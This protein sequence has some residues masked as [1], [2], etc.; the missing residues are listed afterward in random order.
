MNAHADYGTAP[1]TS[2]SSGH[3]GNSFYLTAGLLIADIVGV[4][5]LSMGAVMKQFGWA[6]GILATL[7]AVLFTTHVSILLDRVCQAYPGSATMGQLAYNIYKDRGD[8]VASRMKA[9]TRA[10]QGIY[11]LSLL[12]LNTLTGGKALGMI[13]YDVQVCL[14]FWSL[15]MCVVIFPFM[16]TTQKL[17]GW[18]WLVF[19]NIATIVV[20]VIMPLAQLYALG[21]EQTRINGGNIHAV[22]PFDLGNWFEGALMLVFSCSCQMMVV[23]I[24]AE[25][26]NPLDFPRVFTGTAAPFMAVLFTIVGCGGYYLKG[27]QIQGMVVDSMSFGIAFRAASTALFTHM[28]ISYIIKGIVVV[29]SLMECFS[30]KENFGSATRQWTLWGAIVMGVV[31]STWAAGQ[32]VPFFTDLVDLT[33]AAFTP[34]ACFILPLLFYLHFDRSTEGQHTSR[35]ERGLI[36]LE[37]AFVTALML[38]GTFVASARIAEKWETYGY[39]FDCHC[40]ALW[41]TCECSADHSGMEG[42]C[43]LQQ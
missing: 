27:D 32:V 4:G 28:V 38:G 29:T 11:I 34:V 41:N 18:R 17:G 40:E 22:T 26:H 12:G 31:L 9:F 39:P 13:F 5:I 2:G 14:P 23:E 15:L 16:A 24:R 36:Y 10:S 37:L 19:V 8:D 42:A 33:G 43:P 21:T 35:W 7:G 25:M 30:A 6:L 3:G 1:V 20:S